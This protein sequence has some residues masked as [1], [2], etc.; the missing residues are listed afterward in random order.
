M[1]Y[2]SIKV[3]DVWSTSLCHI[4]VEVIVVDRF[5]PDNATSVQRQLIFKLMN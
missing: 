2:Y 1:Y 3:E 5:I 4:C